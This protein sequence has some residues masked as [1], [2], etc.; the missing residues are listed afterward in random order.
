MTEATKPKRTRPDLVTGRTVPWGT[1]LSPEWIER[2]RE[3]CHR[4]RIKANDLIE[5]AVGAYEVEQGGGQF[6]ARLE[7]LLTQATPEQRE[8]ARAIIDRLET[9]NPP[10]PRESI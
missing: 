6:M 4:D 5:R 2:I 3:I 10:A 8:A 9:G 7:L 1:K